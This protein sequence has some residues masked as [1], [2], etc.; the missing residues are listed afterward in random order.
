MAG[1]KASRARSKE[2]RAKDRRAKKS[3]MNAQYQKWAEEGINQKS[4]RA[5]SRSKKARTRVQADR[6]VSDVNLE[7]LVRFK[8]LYL[9]GYDYQ[10]HSRYGSEVSMLIRQR[11]SGMEEAWSAM[12]I[13]PL[14]SDIP[15]SY[16]ASNWGA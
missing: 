12:N 8:L 4:G 15:V 16:N 3:Q 6:S 14:R 13:V 10:F 9:A 5:H 1:G 2:R 11:W 7:P